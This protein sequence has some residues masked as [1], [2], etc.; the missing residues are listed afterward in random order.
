M[1]AN[2]SGLPASIEQP[3]TSVVHT[4]STVAQAA[5]QERDAAADLALIEAA[6]PYPLRHHERGNGTYGI[7]EHDP[8]SGFRTL[9]DV[10]DWPNAREIAEYLVNAPPAFRYWINRCVA[11]ERKRTFEDVIHSLEP[12]TQVRHTHYVFQHKRT[13]AQAQ[14]LADALREV[15]PLPHSIHEFDRNGCHALILTCGEATNNEHEFTLYYT[16]EEATVDAT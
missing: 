15:M 12:T 14:T 9:V 10:W 7:E 3:A 8:A 13:L 16:P 4:D 11:A 2:T 6:F 1:T 5:A